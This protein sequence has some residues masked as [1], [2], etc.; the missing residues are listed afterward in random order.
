MVDPATRD[1]RVYA[2]GSTACIMAFVLALGC[3]GLC[4]KHDHKQ[5]KRIVNYT[6]ECSERGC[7]KRGCYVWSDNTVQCEREQ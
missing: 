4:L 3:L 1:L 5:G 6:N 7:S 2:I